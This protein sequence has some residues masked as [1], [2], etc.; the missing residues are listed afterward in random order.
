[1]RPAD[2][3]G[4]LGGEEFAML[5]PDTGE[6]EAL[7]RAERLRSTLAATS[8]VIGRCAVAATLSVGVTI[9]DGANAD[10]DTLLK[11]AD[12]ALYRAKIAG[13]NCVQC[14]RQSPQLQPAKQRAVAAR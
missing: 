8:H 2:L 5:L 12:K 3:F 10:L 14:S 1:M 13:R 9:S 4:R 7:R 6:Q 11:S